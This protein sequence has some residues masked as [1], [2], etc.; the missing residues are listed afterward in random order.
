MRPR[1]LSKGKRNA[2]IYIG[3]SAMK[4]APKPKKRVAKKAH[5]AKRK[6]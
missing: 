1:R 4:R 6:G 2:L 5:R 3:R